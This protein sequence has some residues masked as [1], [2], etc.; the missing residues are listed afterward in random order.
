MARPLPQRLISRS[1]RTSQ[2]AAGLLILAGAL[3]LLGWL[4]GFAPLKSLGQGGAAMHPATAL[5]FL[6]A[7]ISLHALLPEQPPARRLRFGQVA[8]V[9]VTLLAL[10][11]LVSQIVRSGP[12]GA[13]DEG[14]LSASRIEKNTAL[15][16]LLLGFA[17][18]LLDFEVKGGRRPAQ[19]LVLTAAGLTVLGITGYAYESLAA[20]GV[21]S[22]LPV[23]INAWLLL[24]VL[25]GGLLTAR[26]ER[27]LMAMA[28]S[29]RASGVLVRRLLPAALLV[30]AI[31]GWLSLLGQ[32]QGWYGPVF[33]MSLLVVSAM[34]IF[35]ALIWLNAWLLYRADRRRGLVED[36]L[37]DSEALYHS[38]VETLPLN[39]FRKDLAGRITF[40]NRRYCETLKTPLE[41]L[42]G[43]TDFD[44]FPTALAEKYRQDDQQVIATG[45]VFETVEV[46]QTTE[47]RP[48]YVHVLKAPVF[49]AK[50]TIIGTQAIFWDVSEKMQA[51]ESL[52]Q[53]RNLLH[54]LM[55]NIP[56]SIYFKDV[57]SR[58]I[59]IN[60]AMAV[61][62]GMGE[63]A[64][65]VGKTDFDYFGAEH[66]DDAFRDEQE[67]MRSGVAVIGKEEKEI[68][69]DGRVG[70]VSTTKMPLRDAEGKIIG[71]FGM[72]RDI[73][74]MKLAEVALQ[75]AKEAAE[76]ANRAK[77]DFL[78]NMS[79]EIRTPMN[80]IIGMTELVL[81]TNLAPEQREFIGLAKQSA[82]SLL[83]LLN[84][85]L[86]FSKIEAGKLDLDPLPFNLRESLGKTL[87]TLAHRAEEKGLELACRIH[88]DVP[89]GL[90]GDVNR[91]RQVIVNLVGNAIKF[92]A[93]GEVVVRVQNEPSSEAATDVVE[94]EG[95]EVV[96][97]RFSVRDTGIGI[98]ADKQGLI[99]QAF[100]QADSSTTRKYGGTG[101]GLTISSQ[102]VELMGGRIELESESGRGSTFSFLAHLGRQTGVPLSRVPAELRDLEQ[103]KVL[104]VD[105]NATNRTILCEMLSGW[106]MN[107]IAIDNARDAM[108]AMGAA[109]ELG[110]P[111]SLVLL[112]AMMPEVDGFTLAAEIKAR[113][114]LSQATL[115]MLSSGDYS[116]GPSRC[117]GLG[118]DAFMTK[119][120]KQSSLLN[121]ILDCCGQR[122]TGAANR[123]DAGTPSTESRKPS[124]MP[125]RQLKILLAEDSLVN[126][127]LAV[128][129]LNQAGH[130][131]LVANDGKEAVAA[132]AAQDFD[133]VLMDVQMPEMDGLEATRRIREREQQTGKH[134]PIVA[135]TAHAMK[136]DRERCLAAGMDNYISKPIR[137]D[138][139]YRV[140]GEVVGVE[141]AASQPTE[142]VANATASGVAS[143][144][145]NGWDWSP[146]L[147]AV[148]GDR[149]LLKEIVDAFLEDSPRRIEQIGEA[150]RQGDSTTMRRAAHTIKGSLRYFGAETAF[151]WAQRLEAIAEAG[152]LADVPEALAGLERELAQLRPQLANPPS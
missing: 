27:G 103:M 77:S 79:H 25:C 21:N 60:R 40:V 94:K 140:I 41:Q 128:G 84:D 149:A 129:L 35:A 45:R 96:V 22:Y 7:G 26:P 114:E 31:L 135:I 9:L 11:L 70:W 87:D 102:L 105:D 134:L 133:L 126:Q 89:D 62:F 19:F 121:A 139:L 124:R 17:L 59:R 123:G 73:T 39:I 5:A 101:L 29:D 83:T 16:L 64:S 24:A 42:V 4:T 12:I 74:V 82:D 46:H 44:L 116:D 65:G 30:P 50:E 109:R 85:I 137:P 100:A 38:L 98:P 107:P 147:S 75:D 2:T 112:D 90:I 138:E 113:S 122:K 144:N 49:G 136:G 23:E 127:K 131:I 110:Q 28:V 142:V 148:R 130:Q 1:L 80:A 115:M 88:P 68:W 51:E 86:D 37:S 151:N 33:G 92:T 6:L 47:G 71:T 14:S 3:V 91:L 111:F 53:E 13:P 146:A 119:P 125:Q 20:D 32:R 99:F 66:A 34:V 117:R 18:V 93:N 69:K 104:I 72:S 78:A 150:L 106:R 81:N 8:A 143:S 56:D 48:N 76:A 145:Q 55:D 97:L 10:G 152:K 141:G 95:E 118:V 132:T 108:L 58:F 61:K 43:R 63:P 15:N 57:E 67:M 36:A 120:I 52:T 54:A